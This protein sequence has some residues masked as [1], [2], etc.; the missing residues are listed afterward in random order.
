MKT[1][2]ELFDKEPVENIYTAT[3]L[4]PERVVFV[5]DARLMTGA[6]QEN[7]RRYFAQKGLNSEVYFYAIRTDDIEQISSVLDEITRHFD[8]C[9]C[10]VTGGTDLLLVSAG[11]LCERKKIPVLFFNVHTGTFVNVYGCEHLEEKYTPPAL[12]TEDFM[13]LAGGAFIRHGHYYPELEEPDIREQVE[14]VWEVIRKDL[15]GWGKQA[16][17]FQQAGKNGNGSEKSLAVRAP[18]HIHI[19]FKN[20]V[21]C[22]PR[23]MMRL[24]E[25][26][27]IYN[28]KMENDKV[29]FTYKNDLFKRLLSDAGVWLE[30]YTYYTAQR[31]GFFD[32][33]QTSVIIDWDG[34]SDSTGTVNE[35]DDILVK[36]I[37]PLFVSCKIGVPSVLAINEINTLARRFGGSMAKPVLVTASPLQD[38]PDP[39]R[40]RAADMGVS[41]LEAGNIPRQAFA[42]ALMKL[43]GASKDYFRRR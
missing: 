31:T 40:Q 17:Y 1:L 23:F 12:T 28:Y 25:T 21:H 10:D 33:V 22:N 6:R 36:G 37:V 35:L 43:A 5:G 29:R 18:V 11:M 19:S 32:D 3:A 26:G 42:R 2:I 24:A 8:G 41:L 38:I 16:S 14:A 7:T 20:I 9:V 27:V 39:I 13:V 4:R 15:P 34:M 30:L